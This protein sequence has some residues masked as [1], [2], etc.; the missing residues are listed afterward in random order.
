MS[1]PKLNGATPMAQPYQANPM[2]KAADGPL[3]D[4][5]A[6]KAKQDDG[7]S[8]GDVLSGVADVALGATSAVAPLLPGGQVIGLAAN[9]LSQLKNSAMGRDGGPQDQVDKM[10]AMQQENQAFNMQYMQL[11]QQMQADNRNFSTL[12]NLLKVRHDTAKSAINNMH[13]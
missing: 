12:S 10:W 8:F 13:A 2:S 6:K 7:I 4:K 5:Q 9:G 1:H 11:Q 3:T